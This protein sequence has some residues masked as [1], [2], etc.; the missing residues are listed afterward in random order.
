[1]KIPETDSINELAEV[2]DTRDLTEFED[3]LE[4][5][6][7]RALPTESAT[8]VGGAWRECT[9]PPGCSRP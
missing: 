1:M 6:V 2:W 5:G 4:E 3:Q 7:T 8:H 9:Q